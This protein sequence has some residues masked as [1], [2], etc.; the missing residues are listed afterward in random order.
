[1]A[2]RPCG[3]RVLLFLFAIA[4]GVP[5]RGSIADDRYSANPD[6]EPTA[7]CG[8]VVHAASVARLKDG[9]ADGGPGLH[10]GRV[11]AMPPV[12][13]LAVGPAAEAPLRRST[14]RRSLNLASRPPPRA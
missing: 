12:T 3:L 1:M 2:V 4:S 10:A 7:I 5:P 11:P 13:A 14:D 9:H 6:G 8:T